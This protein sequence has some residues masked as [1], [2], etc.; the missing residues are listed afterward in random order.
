MCEGVDGPIG[1]WLGWIDVPEPTLAGHGPWIDL[2]HPLSN[3]M[4]RVPIMP[5]PHFGHW[6]KMPDFPA[7]VT[8]MSMIVHIGTH[9]DAPRH[10]FTDA[11]T[12]DQIPLP[13]LYGGGV[14]WHIDA[15]PL[16]MIEPADLQAQRPL[17]QRGD[18]LMI[19]TGWW[20]RA[21]SAE[22]HRHPGLS[23]AS[24]EWLAEQGIK[25][26]AV[27]CG[28]PEAATEARWPGWHWPVHHALLSRGILVTEHVRNLQILGGQRIEAMLLGLN[29]KG[30][31]GA[32]ARVVARPAS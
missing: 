20:A 7:N 9:V 25:M 5:Q 29:I 4:P 26:L 11:P 12:F 31:D 21:D 22:Y 27:D 19:D 18:I 23:L 14:V 13:R 32:P 6:R 3:D 28:T 1:K 17:L 16:Q 8:E 30:G 15:K 24:A 2:S 10:F